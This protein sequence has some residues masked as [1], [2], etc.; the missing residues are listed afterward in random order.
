MTQLA[1]T[2]RRRLSAADFHP[3]IARFNRTLRSAEPQ[4]AQH[5]SR[6]TRGLP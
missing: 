3:E 6:T 1:E 2:E 5:G 4:R